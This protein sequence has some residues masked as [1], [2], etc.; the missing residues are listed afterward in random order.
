MKLI[1]TL[2]LKNG[3]LLG[4]ISVDE[5]VA[6]SDRNIV[7]DRIDDL[8]IDLSTTSSK[9]KYEIAKILERFEYETT[10]EEQT[11]FEKILFSFLLKEIRNWEKVQEQLLIYFNLKYKKEFNYDEEFPIRL[12]DDFYLRKD[13]FSG[14]MNM[15]RELQDYLQKKVE[16]DYGNE[17]FM[18][19]VI[20]E[21]V[22]D[23]TNGSQRNYQ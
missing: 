16:K 17:S 5:I 2:F 8:F 9:T 21:L 20:G 4:L 7:E 1:N 12:N 22:N 19:T 14:N 23:S 13:G 3:V 11:K 6:W 10:K 18:E 15:P